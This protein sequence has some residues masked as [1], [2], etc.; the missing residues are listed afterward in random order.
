MVENRRVIIAGAGPV[1]CVTALIL[2]RAGI[3]VTILEAENDLQMD[4]RASTFHPPTLD[5]L[6]DLDVTPA[7]MTQGL[8]SPTFQY[9]DR[10]NG[11][12]A[13]FDLSG[14]SAHTRHPFRLQ[15]EQFKLTI[16]LARRLKGFPETQ[17]LFG[18]RL[19][20]LTQTADKVCVTY[21]KDGSSHIVEGEYLV[22]ADGARSL[23]RKSLGIDFPGFTYPELFV[24]ASTS[25]DL[26]RAMP[27]LANVS[28]ISDPDE[29][30]A[31]I[32]APDLWRFLF[33]VKPETSR[34][35]ALTTQYLQPRMQKMVPKAQPYEIAHRTLYDVHQ[36]VAERYR[37]GRV[38]LAGDSAHINNPLGGMGM[39]GGIH[40]AVNLAEKLVDVMTGKSPESLLDRYER[41]RRPVAIEYVQAQTH[42][43]KQTLEE[44]DPEVRRQ[45]QQ[46]MKETAGDPV[47]AEA[48]MLK[49]SMIDAVRKSQ[50]LA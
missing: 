16:E 5:M 37:E 46:E 45:R 35:E 14:L 7:L 10:E 20:S 33:P 39:N 18:A 11:L 21:V 23:V 41:Q 25:E 24:V 47:R 44:R 4:L 2:S 22:A 28:Y 8:I 29:W 9:R 31:L 43:N 3:P 50:S 40:D 27:G 42:R 38:F 26:T 15:C 32:R 1:G 13:E 19:E 34:E 30:C 6:A 12:L 36:R 48:L 49:V 17:M